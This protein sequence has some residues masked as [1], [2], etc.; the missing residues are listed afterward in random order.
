M[1][2][3]EAA[4]LGS[5]EP[6]CLLIKL[7]WIT[8]LRAWELLNSSSNAAEMLG[9][10]IKIS[11]YAL[12]VCSAHVY[13]MAVLRVGYVLC[14]YNNLENSVFWIMQYSKVFRKRSNEIVKPPRNFNVRFLVF[15]H[16]KFSINRLKKLCPNDHFMTN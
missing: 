16:Q 2:A 6:I 10:L 12:F 13:V 9:C 1:H 11:F 7:I 14:V 3:M 15:K 5:S 8:G 4:I